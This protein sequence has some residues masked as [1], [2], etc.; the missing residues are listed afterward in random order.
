VGFTRPAIHLRALTLYRDTKQSALAQDA[1]EGTCVCMA[2]TGRRI[3]GGAGTGGERV[4][5]PGRKDLKTF[6]EAAIKNDYMSAFG[7][8][9]DHKDRVILEFYEIRKQQKQIFR[10]GF[11]SEIT[12]ENYTKEKQR[13]NKESEFFHGYDEEFKKRTKAVSDR[14][15][16][17]MTKNAAKVDDMH[18]D[19]QIQMNSQRSGQNQ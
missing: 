11:T 6:V 9:G 12:L 17:G 16:S 5:G 1:K 10:D 2:S 13:D 19:M 4:G 18:M 8:S 14:V 15:K 7:A 3:G